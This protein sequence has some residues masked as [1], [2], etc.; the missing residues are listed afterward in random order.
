[1][2]GKMLDI[3]G[4]KSTVEAVTFYVMSTVLLVGL[5]TTLM[6]VLGMVGVVGTVGTFFEG[7]HFHTLVGTG[8][9]MVLSSLIV[10]GRKMTDDLFA[11]LLVV[12]GVYL[13]YTTSIVLGLVPLALL[14]TLTKK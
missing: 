7:G 5:S 13:T 8:F 9:V 4:T 2:L 10:T 12:L 14:T 11:I 3:T 6:H 1:M